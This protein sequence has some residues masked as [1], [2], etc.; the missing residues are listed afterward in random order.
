MTHIA[1]ALLDGDPDLKNLFGMWIF[2]AVGAVSL[3]GI[4]LPITVFLENRRKERDSFYKAETFRRL[5]EASGDGAKSAM[6]L[7]REQS[8]LE[9]LK[10][11]EGLKIGGLITLAVG[12]ALCIFL[13]AA[14]TGPGN[15]GAYLVGLIPGL[16]GVAMLVY[17]LFMAGPLE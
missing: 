7:L 11:R 17:A 8:R 16:V 4:F 9:Q 1:I 13:R 6:D 10:R 5:S 2:L 3:F 12:V 14:A 15:H